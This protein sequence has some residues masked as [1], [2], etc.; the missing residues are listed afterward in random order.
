VNNQRYLGGIA[1]GFCIISL[2]ISPLLAQGQE[3]ETK[4]TFRA[5][6]VVT[7][8]IATGANTTVQMTVSRWSSDEERAELLTTL[9]EKGQE[10]FIEALSKQEETGFIRVTGRGANLSRFPSQRLRYAREFREGNMRRIVLALDRPIGFM[11]AVRNPRTT[12]YDF[13]FIVFDI[14]EEEN[15]GQGVMAVGVKLKVDMEKKTL[16][17]ENYSSEPVRLTKVSKVE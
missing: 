5:F 14:N 11:E 9:I 2:G 12:D 6:A 1:I 7:G 13:T 8:N 10:D 15:E 16:E 4:E 17:V 3:E